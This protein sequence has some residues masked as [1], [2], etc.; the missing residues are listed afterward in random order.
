MA[1]A[2]VSEAVAAGS[3]VT[4]VMGNADGGSSGQ[5][6]DGSTL[7]SIPG[8]YSILNGVIGVGSFDASTGN[9]S[10]F[11]HYSTTYAEIGARV[12]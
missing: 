2:A 5:M 10:L 8:Q 4:V 7:S 9:K 6:I 11:S 12:Q 1:Q 3:F